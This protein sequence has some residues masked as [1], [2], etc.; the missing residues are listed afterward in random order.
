VSGDESVWE[1]AHVSVGVRHSRNGMRERERL[2][3]P[4]AN[5]PRHLE[6]KQNTTLTFASRQSA[7][8]GGSGTSRCRTWSIAS[9]HRLA[10]ASTVYLG[11]GEERV[12]CKSRVLVESLKNC[13]LI[14]MTRRVCP[15][16]E[17]KS[18]YR[19]TEERKSNDIN[20]N[21]IVVFNHRVQ[22]L[23]SCRKNK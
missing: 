5:L 15:C 23:R 4:R 19:K 13:F 20:T 9:C 16:F 6:Q 7:R 11:G 8:S 21:Q 17:F 14:L 3:F 12:K 2:K 10:C 1:A 22:T 18:K